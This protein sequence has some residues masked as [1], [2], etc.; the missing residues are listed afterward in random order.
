MAAQVTHNLC[1]K[2][3]EYTTTDGQ[4]KKRWLRIGSVFRHDDGGTSIKLDAVPVG[5]PNWDGW[6]SVFKNDQG[7]Q[8]TQP[9]QETQQRQAPARQAQRAQAGR[10]SFQPDVNLDDDIPF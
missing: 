9:P 4:D 10:E 6:V 1:V 5:L 2:T 8:N 7:G 3:G